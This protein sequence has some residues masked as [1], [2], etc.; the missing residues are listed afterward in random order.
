M[1]NTAST[2]LIL[3][4]KY[5]ELKGKIER[6]ARQIFEEWREKEPESTSTRSF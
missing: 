5:I 4:W 6:K 1:H 2:S 3:L